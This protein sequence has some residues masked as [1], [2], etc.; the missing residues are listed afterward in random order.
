MLVLKLLEINSDMVIYEY[1]PENNKEHP[2]KIALNL[3][4]KERIFLE[5]SK[6][7]FGRRYAAHGLKRIEEYDL[8]GNFEEEGLVA[9]Y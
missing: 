6:E 4:T 8:N 2:G 9:W 1:Y 5:D 3:K 7:D